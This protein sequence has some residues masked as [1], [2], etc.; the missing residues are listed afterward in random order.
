MAGARSVPGLKKAVLKWG[1]SEKSIMF[2]LVDN[3]PSFCDLYL[4]CIFS[5]FDINVFVQKNSGKIP[6][7]DLFVSESYLNELPEFM[8]SLRTSLILPLT[9]CRNILYSYAL[10]QVFY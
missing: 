7:P 2:C 3:F 8:K 1:C 10:P 6:K 5:T 9:G 4:T